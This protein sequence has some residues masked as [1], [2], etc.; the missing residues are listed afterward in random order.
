[1]KKPRNTTT[2]T[3]NPLIDRP[4][5]NTI[6]AWAAH[7]IGKVSESVFLTAPGVRDIKYFKEHDIFNSKARITIFQKDPDV[8]DEILDDI[9]AMNCDLNAHFHVGNIFNSDPIS[10]K[11]EFM[12]VDTC[13]YL[14]RNL[15]GWISKW[16]VAPL[17]RMVF[18]FQLGGRA[19]FAEEIIMYML[20][21][22]EIDY[23]HNNLDKIKAMNSDGKLVAYM[24]KDYE[25]CKSIL[26]H[27][28]ETLGPEYMD[29]M[30]S[31]MSNTERPI[32]INSLCE[33]VDATTHKQK[34]LVI[35]NIMALYFLVT[36]NKNIVA[37]GTDI[38]MAQMYQYAHGIGIR[39]KQYLDKI[40]HR[41]PYLCVS[42]SP[43]S[44]R[45]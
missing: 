39:Q 41:F 22:R 14:P 30:L 33:H 27:N 1:M 4:Y 18:T 10:D 23:L 12:F 9:V 43:A 25:Y 21:G 7:D 16:N 32:S 28:A 38:P 42:T 45:A 17:K 29:R 44:A 36:Y 20:L 5:K 37:N 11:T 24:T 40:P 13:G 35:G 15:N 19:G 3:Y 2:T 26:C 31:A 34:H 6:Y 8:V